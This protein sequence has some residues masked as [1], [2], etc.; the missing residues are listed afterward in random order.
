MFECLE[1]VWFKPFLFLQSSYR[2]T[3]RKIRQ[4]IWSIFSTSCGV[5]YSAIYSANFVKLC[6]WKKQQICVCQK[7]KASCDLGI[8]VVLVCKPVVNHM[9]LRRRLFG[10][11][12]HSPKLQCF[13]SASLCGHGGL[14]MSRKMKGRNAAKVEP[15]YWEERILKI[16]QQIYT[17]SDNGNESSAHITLSALNTLP[18]AFYLISYIDQVW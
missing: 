5:I 11:V 16:C 14:K 18:C 9:T 7:C 4:T 15:V 8:G 12:S 2:H 1:I 3:F 10:D 6:C 17:D 13:Y